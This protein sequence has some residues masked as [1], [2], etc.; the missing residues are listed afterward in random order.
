MSASDVDT[1][2]DEL[3]VWGAECLALRTIALDVGLTEEWKW[4][5]PCYTHAGKN[6][7]MVSPFKNYASLSFFQGVLLTDSAQRL[8]VPG[9]DSQSARQWRF[10]SAEQI[11]NDR[12]LIAAYLR[13]AMDH[14]DAGTSVPFTAKDELVFPDELL[15][16]FQTIPGLEEAFRSLTPGRQR[17]FI[18]NIESAKQSKTR[19]ARVDKHTDRILAGKGIHDCVCGKSTKMPRCDGSHAR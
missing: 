5:Q 9:K 4:K 14:V 6:V 2:F 3:E 11:G 13:E 15:E 8:T 10:D 18:L 17:G 19:L 1:F 12:E 7:A 16:R